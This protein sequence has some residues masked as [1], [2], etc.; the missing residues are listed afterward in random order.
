M[1]VKPFGTNIDSLNSQTAQN[2]L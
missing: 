2:K 1:P